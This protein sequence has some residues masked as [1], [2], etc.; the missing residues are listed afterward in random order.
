MT[1]FQSEDPRAIADAIVRYSATHDVPAE[2]LVA[3][4]EQTFDAASVELPADGWSVVSWPRRLRGHI[5][6]SRW[7]S[8]ELGVAA[9][10]VEVYDSDAWTHVALD[11]G[12]VRDRFATMPEAQTSDVTSRTE[13]K[14]RW[15]GNAGTV[16]ELFGRPS[17]DVAP[18]FQRPSLLR[19]LW[20]RLA[21]KPLGVKAFPDDEYNLDED[22]V[23]T[24][25][26]RR[27]GITYPDPSTSPG[28]A[29]VVRFHPPGS[30]EL[31][32]DTS[33]D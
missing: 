26:W 20:S 30:E 25:F 14:R 16:A 32:Y 17:S 1:A 11:R 18:Y 8:G 24:D 27:A 33:L 13:A 15:A 21:G 4:P 10:L 2:V 23:F 28:A 31:P 5:K 19:V 9:S 6:I 3:E 12:E 22:W 7:L 29:H